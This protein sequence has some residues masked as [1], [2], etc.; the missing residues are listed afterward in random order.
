MSDCP[1]GCYDCSGLCLCECHK[2]A[3]KTA[4]VRRPIKYYDDLFDDVAEGNKIYYDDIRFL[5]LSNVDRMIKFLY[6]KG[7]V[8]VGN[9]F[10][11]GD[12]V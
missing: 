3:L 12:N 5:K 8:L 7:Y 6:S 10:I 11:Y 2:A 1:A 4:Q 9:V